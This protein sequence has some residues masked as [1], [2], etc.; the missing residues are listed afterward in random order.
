LVQFAAA[1]LLLVTAAPATVVRVPADA[2]SVTAAVAAAPSGARIEIDAGVFSPRTS[3]ESFPIT[4]T[5]RRLVLAGAGAGRTVLRGDGASALFVFLDGDESR[6]SGMTLAGGRAAQGG[7]VRIED[8]SPAVERIHFTDDEAENGGDAVAVLGGAPR[9]ANCLFVANG[10][11]GPTVLVRSGSP[12]LEHN[13]FHAN[14]GAALEVDT[15]AS[16]L[17]RATI[18]SRPG[19]PAGDAVG[20]RI[21]AGPGLGGLVLEDNLFSGCYDGTVVIEGR[22]EEI[23][24]G[25]REDARRADG[26]REGDPLFTAP[27]RGD[28]RLGASSPARRFGDPAAQ[29]GAFGGPDPLRLDPTP[30]TWSR[31]VAPQPRLLGPSIPNPFTPATTIHFTVEEAGA[32]DLGIYNVL[33]Q[34]IRTLHSGDLS[35]GEHSR[36]WDG[37]DDVGAEAP[38]G[39]YFVR[40]TQG[41]VTE[42]RRVVLVR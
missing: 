16:P 23:L 9:V 4:L 40:V 37:R 11:R 36:V 17:V 8:A 35:A 3:G 20:L 42:S 18:V 19:D 29:I 6:I 7:A 5:G 38:P 2:P 30:E 32:V 21:V 34:R 15:G 25:V 39:I 22:S 28:F 31:L 26:L 13:T 1:W 14:G 41:E 33:G 27:R 24:P 10:H 12:I